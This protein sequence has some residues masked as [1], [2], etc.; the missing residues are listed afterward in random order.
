MNPIVRKRET[1]ERKIIP[2]GE[3]RIKS[4]G[5]L[6]AIIEFPMLVDSGEGY[7]EK[8]F[9]QF[10]RP[11]G[12]R[13]IAVKDE[14]IFLQKEHRLE[15]KNG[16]DWRLPGGK[17]VDSFEEYEKYI[18]KEMPEDIIIAAGKRELEEEANLT[19][20]S[21]RIFKKSRC[22][23]SVEWDLYYIIA[24]EIES[25][26]HIHDEGEEITDRKWFS[27]TE[28]MTMCQNGDIDE[29]RTIAT[30]YQYCNKN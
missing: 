26:E 4:H 1:H 27:Y 14:K 16:F 11:P 8:N 6:G 2:N 20:K 9:E 17:V 24:E 23:A 15:A 25:A 28:I 7:V 10:V 30:L 21:L 19:A 22:G 3:P 18:G 12:T 29:D 13:I 5:R